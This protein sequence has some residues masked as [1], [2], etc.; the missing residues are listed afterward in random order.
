MSLNL[1]L[2]FSEFNLRMDRSPGEG[3]YEFDD[4]R[5]D[6]G[7][8]MLYHRGEPVQLAPKAAAGRAV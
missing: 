6:V 3:I 7:H 4:F 8:L 5:F 2:A 1:G